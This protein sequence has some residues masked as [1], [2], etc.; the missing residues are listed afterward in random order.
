MATVLTFNL[1][2][3][4]ANTNQ[5]W[6]FSPGNYAVVLG[7]ETSELWRGVQGI[8]AAFSPG[9][10][11]DIKELFGVTPIGGDN[12]T[13][14]PSNMAVVT[15]GSAAAFDITAIDGY[16]VA[17]V[18]VS[19]AAAKMRTPGARHGSPSVNGGGDPRDLVSRVNEGERWRN[20]PS[21]PPSRPAAQGRRGG[22]PFFTEAVPRHATLDTTLQDPHI[23]VN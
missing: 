2:L 4:N 5:D 10:K 12:H 22:P 18:V 14:S 23:I 21:L 8:D 11:S 19:S 6:T 1:D 16:R 20:A 7:E 3:L 15:E 17:A 9:K 13:I